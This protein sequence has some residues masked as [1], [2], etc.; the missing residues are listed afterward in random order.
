MNA[1]AERG[2]L[3]IV[4]AP[5]GAGKTSL[6]QALV[7]SDDR[8]EV[9]VSHTTRPI[10]PGEVEG[11]NYFFVSEE[12]FLIERERGGFFESATVFGNLYG[13]G[14]AQLEERLARGVDVVL[15][16]DWQ[17]ARQVQERVPDSVWIFILPPSVEALRERL[18]NRGQDASETIEA[19]MLAARDEMSHWQDADYLIVNEYFDQALE[20]LR[21]I[22]AS[23]RLGV[24]RQKGALTPLINQLLEG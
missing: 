11:E 3:L 18:D 9:S 15:E 10:R 16:I 4:S 12:T 1:V 7:A 23:L 20:A 22:V 19:R 13:T 24:A 5:S 8:I 14:V 17:G 21:T 6:I 2:Q